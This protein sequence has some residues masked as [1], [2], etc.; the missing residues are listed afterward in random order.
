VLEGG[1]GNDILIGGLGKDSFDGGTG[2]DQVDYSLTTTRVM[3]TLR[4][5]SDGVAVVSGTA[6]RLRGIESASGG[7]GADI[8]NGDGAANRL[9]GNAGDDLLDGGAASDVLLGGTGGDSLIGGA[10]NDHADGGAGNDVLDG[11]VGD[12]VLMG[13]AGDDVFIGGPGADSIDGG[14][15]GDG[16]DSDTVDYS[17]AT[18]RIVAS[19]RPGQVADVQIGSVGNTVRWVENIT[20]GAG[21]DQLT[22]TFEFGDV[23]GGGGNDKLHG[24]SD[25]VVEG[26]EGNDTLSAE[27]DGYG[28]A[29]LFGGSG[30]DFLTGNQ[31][32]VRLHDGGSGRDTVDLGVGEGA[33]RYQ[34][35]TAV[36]DGSNSVTVQ[37]GGGSLRLRSIEN[38]RTGDG[39]DNL[40]GDASANTFWTGAGADVLKGGAGADRFWA[41]LGSDEMWGEAGADTF[42]FANASDSR[43]SHVDLIRTW[44]QADLIDL[45]LIDADLTAAGDQDFQFLG[46]GTADQNIGLGQIK[47]YHL[48]GYTFVVAGH[49][50][51]NLAD[52]KLRMEGIRTLTQDDFL[53]LSS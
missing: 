47:Y 12:D 4:G 45:K 25:G 32:S 30:D 31:S 10:G 49:T 48:D 23:S 33:E 44:D 28:L 6:E 3:L 19:L 43:G 14:F 11:G 37:V 26:G 51:D 27:D 21:H 24:G 53:G 20:G 2:I 35:V 5:A 42:V 46:K 38:V 8:L 29:Q 16:P 36:L 50:D 18:I 22:T 17:N 9:S 15:N 34:A 41:G 52:F 40:T 13:G 7:T 39:I 1:A